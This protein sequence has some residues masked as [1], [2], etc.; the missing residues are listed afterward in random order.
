MLLN[1]IYV[2]LGLTGL[3]F[4]GNWLVEGAAR[5]ARS[6]SISTLVIGL[7]VVA[8]GTSAP[9]LL[10]SITAALKGNSDIAIGNVIGSNVANIGL[11]LGATG[12]ITPIAVH[13]SLLRREIPILLIVT[14][15]AAI[16]VANGTVSRLDG[17]IMVLGLVAFNV[18]M[19]Y[20]AQRDREQGKPF[21]TLEAEIEADESD[22]PL[23][24]QPGQR[25]NEVIRLL[26]G[27]GV[28][29]FAAQLTV[30][31]AVNIARKVGISELVIGI[32]L[33][34]F[35]T[36]L[37]ELATSIMAA[38]RNQSDIAV[39]NIV[40]SNIYNLL[41]ILGVTAII[42][43]INIE[44]HIISFDGWVMIGFT[45]LLLPFCWNR[46]IGKREGLFLLTCF[47]TYIGITVF[48]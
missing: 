13:I 10:V 28:L 9:E 20:L 29:I 18:G 25:L 36:S 43:P 23:E 22:E 39:G 37:P 1:F 45:F 7:T 8:F 11:I 2:A 17:F 24:I 15:G 34:A 40:G 19:L 3:Y 14:I 12:L 27:L 44:A 46:V 42:R 35:G 47:F 48:V 38:T 41:G 31:G 33:I 16:L 21:A 6:F 30:E 5:L 26:V 4:G 32:T